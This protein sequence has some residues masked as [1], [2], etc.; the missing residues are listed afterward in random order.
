MNF[1]KIINVDLLKAAF[2]RFH[3]ALFT[4]FPQRK[5]VTITLP[6]DVTTYTYSDAWIT[7]DTDCYAHNLDDKNI[8]TTISWTFSDGYVTFTMND[9]LANSVSFVFGMI[10]G[11]V[12]GS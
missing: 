9:E 3:A 7:A 8:S 2:A 10:K 11:E 5:K 1:E 12:T 6:S 4:L